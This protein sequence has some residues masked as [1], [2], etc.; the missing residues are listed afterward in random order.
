MLEATVCN[1][2]DDGDFDTGFGE[3]GVD[4]I[5]LLEKDRMCN[6]RVVG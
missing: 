2:D 4:M 1:A 6:D 5:D 3:L